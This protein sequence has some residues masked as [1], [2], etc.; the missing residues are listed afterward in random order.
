MSSNDSGP[1]RFLSLLGASYV[2]LFKFVI[3]VH[4]SCL[5]SPGSPKRQEEPLLNS[6]TDYEDSIYGTLEPLDIFNIHYNLNMT[7]E[8]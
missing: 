2:A 3:L 8:S 7:S 6:Y 4:E 5:F 1:D